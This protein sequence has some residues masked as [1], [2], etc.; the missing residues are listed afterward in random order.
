MNRI[1]KARL[2]VLPWLVGVALLGGVAPAA[3]QGRHHACLAPGGDDDTAAL[4]AALDR[5]SGATRP[6]TVTLCA[7][8]FRTGILR[9]RDFR[10]TLRGR[11]PERTVLRALPDLPVSENSRDFFRDG[12]VRPE[13]GLA[14]PRPVHRRPG[15]RRGPRDPGPGASARLHA[16]DGLVPARRRADLRAPGSAALQRP[17]AGRLRGARRARRG[18]G[19]GDRPRDHDLRRGGVRRAPA[20]TPTTWGASRCSR[21]RAACTSPTAPSTAC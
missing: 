7:G 20:T 19:P 4:Q 18:R 3:A 21:R 8:T 5:C 11:G 16:D 6:C 12:S 1:T 13:P 17:Q 14:V 2:L 9:V 10:G 15:P